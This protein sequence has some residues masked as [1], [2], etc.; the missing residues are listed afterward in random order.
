MKK[1]LT[2]GYSVAHTRRPYWYIYGVEYND[3]GGGIII[4]ATLEVE[5]TEAS[6]IEAFVD[7]INFD[8]DADIYAGPDFYIS[9]DSLCIYYRSERMG[10]DAGETVYSLPVSDAFVEHLEL[11]R[12]LRDLNV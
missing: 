3:N 1:H 6:I 11:L 10:L 5:P 2:I 12:T 7:P 8:Q 4:V 9:F